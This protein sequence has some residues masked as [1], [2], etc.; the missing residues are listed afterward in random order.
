M[1]GQGLTTQQVKQAFQRTRRYSNESGCDFEQWLGNERML[2]R[3]SALQWA[4]NGLKEA[5]EL[6]EISSAVEAIDLLS[7]WKLR[8]D[9]LESIELAS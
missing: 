6:Y 1:T 4:L 7:T 9:E 2:T 5:Y 8:L 3:M